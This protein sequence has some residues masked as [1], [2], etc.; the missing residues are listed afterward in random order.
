MKYLALFSFCLF[1][2]AA[3]GDDTFTTDAGP[4][5]DTFQSDA[6]P[7]SDTGEDAPLTE[8]AEPIPALEEGGEGHAAPLE[9]PVG[10]ARAGRLTEADIPADPSDLLVWRAGDWV[11]A[12]EH[13]A[14]VVEDVGIS[15]GY[16]IWGGRSSDSLASKV[17]R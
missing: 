12:N 16:E 13:I 3:C 17:A 6:T 1:A 15:D 4:T 2:F 8:C 5:E 7:P 9:A 11:L 10:E 14:V